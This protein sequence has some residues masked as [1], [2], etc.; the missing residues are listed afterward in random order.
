MRRLTKLVS[1]AFYF[2]VIRFLESMLA[3]EMQHVWIVDRVRLVRVRFGGYAF[4]RE[5]CRSLNKTDIF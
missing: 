5:S 4:P 1:V 3:Y 2:L